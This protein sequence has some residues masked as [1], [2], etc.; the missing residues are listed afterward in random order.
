MKPSLELPEPPPTAAPVVEAELVEGNK[1]R[2]WWR[3]R[4]VHWTLVAVVLL[5]ALAIALEPFARTA[6]KSIMGDVCAARGQAKFYDGD[7]PAALDQLDKAVAWAPEDPGILLLRAQMRFRNNDLK[8]S[9]ED[10]DRVIQLSPTYS[11][12]YAGR[13]Q[14]YQR[15]G[16]YPDAINDLTTALRQQPVWEPQPWNHRAYV[17]ALGGIELTEALDDVNEAIRLAPD[18]NASFLDTRGLILHKLDKNDEALADLNRAIVLT[19]AQRQQWRL[20]GEK[21]QTDPRLRKLR[22]EDFDHAL[23]V[24]HQHRGLVHAALKH[25]AEAKSDA[26]EAQKLGY[27][28]AKGIE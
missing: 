16:R 21:D 1:P 18:E 11:G 26:D 5:G 15:L 27:D 12:G 20:Q 19:T 8:G 28:P 2:P 7:L 22:D 3:S 9:L 10:Y 23:A 25:E 4:W 6:A 17:R 24:M 14:V 13:A